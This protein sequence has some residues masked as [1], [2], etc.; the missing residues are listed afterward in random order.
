MLLTFPLISPRYWSKSWDPVVRLSPDFF[1]AYTNFS[2]VPFKDGHN[3]LDAKT[4]ELI[5]VAI[6]CSTTHLFQV[7]LKLH[8]QNAMKYGATEYEIMEVFELA[9]LM[10]VQT[11]LLGT[12]ALREA[13]GRKSA[14]RKSEG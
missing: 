1:E 5:Y 14:V 3:A 7:G 8:I 4:K 11:T 13:G 12:N 6:D 2:S 10:G 9:A